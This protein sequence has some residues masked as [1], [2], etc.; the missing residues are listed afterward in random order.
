MICQTR[1]RRWS[2]GRHRRRLV[3]AAGDPRGR[4]EG[5]DADQ[6]HDQ[7]KR[8]PASHR[9]RSSQPCSRCAAASAS[10]GARPPVCWAR[11]GREP[12]VL[13]L[14]R[15]LEPRAERLH[16]RFGLARLRAALAAQRQREPDDDQLGLVLGHQRDDPGPGPASLAARSTIPTGRAS[17]PVA[18]DTATPV[19]AA[20]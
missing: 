8:E 12:L 10:S 11:D 3:V 1:E 7:E 4:R 2:G 20:P 6:R 13:C 14:H 16:E 9:A 18:S 19:R 15:N 5:P 17:V